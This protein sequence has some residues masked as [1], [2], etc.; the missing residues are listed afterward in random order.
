MASIKMRCTLRVWILSTS[1]LLFIMSLL[2]TYSHNGTDGPAYL[3]LTVWASA[4]EHPVRLV[5]GYPGIRHRPPSPRLP[6]TCSCRQC[7]W[8]P[9]FSTW[10]DSHYDASVSP[11]WTLENRELSPDVQHWWVMLQPQFRSHNTL[12]IL[13]QLFQIIPGQN[14]YKQ[15]DPMTCRRCAVVGNSGNLRGS[16]YGKDIDGYEFIMRINQAP[17]VGFEMD[18]GSRTTHHFMYPESAKNLPANVSFVLVPFKSLDLLWITSA[19]STG[20]IRFTYAPVKTFLRVDKEKV[21][22]Y[23]P[24]FFKYIHDRWTEHHGR[25][26]STGMLVLFFAL[27][28][29]DEVNVFGFG[30]DSHGNWH[31]YWEN[32][33]YAGEFRK[34][35]VHDADFE[36]H[37][38]DTL[39]REGKIKVY[40]ST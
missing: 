17:T 2:F 13:A 36:A 11:V 23:N 25:Y 8:Q 30:A 16:G 24:A 12:E 38:I 4:N 6:K 39:A 34:T 7:L 35:G 37:I 32:N 14:P 33:R 29:C 9:G 18:V 3:E 28:V 31:H 10:F 5:P 21:Q 26:P 19:L 40:R 27:H 15:Q 22:I 20:Q 1:I